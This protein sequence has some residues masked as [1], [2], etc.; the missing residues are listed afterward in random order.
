MR[1]NTFSLLL[2]HSINLDRF[3]PWLWANLPY[4]KGIVPLRGQHYQSFYPV[5]QAVLVSPLYTVPVLILHV[6]R[7]DVSTLVAFARVYEKI[8]AA[9]LA[10]L[11]V[12]LML[13]V[14]ERLTSRRWAWLLTVSFAFGTT[15]WSIC[16]QALWRRTSG[17]LFIIASIYFLLRWASEPGRTTN[18]WWAGLFAGL[19]VLIRPTNIV[20][21]VAVACGILFAYRHLAASFRFLVL[22]VVCTL[23]LAVDNTL[24]FG[25]ALGGY[26]VHV[27]GR[28]EPF[29]AAF[30]GLIDPV[31]DCSFILPSCYS[32]YSRRSWRAKCAISVRPCWWYHAGYSCFCTLWLLPIGRLGGADGPGGRGC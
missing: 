1:A 12:V 7:W 31:V 6:D 16:S 21:P 29:G 19:T 27:G 32:P 18:L 24:I 11:S 8:I 3:G 26:G 5:A 17:Q 25:T 28:T 22:P 4:S 13:L 30:V 23:I 20:F 15:T 2:D 10:A 14:L 9:L